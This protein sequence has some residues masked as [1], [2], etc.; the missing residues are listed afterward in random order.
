MD[1]ETLPVTFQSLIP[2]I[3]SLFVWLFLGGSIFVCLEGGV[4]CSGVPPI[5]AVVVPGAG[6]VCT[7]LCA[8]SG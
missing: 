3:F 7:P 2:S 8:D 4:S 6:G 5:H 1:T